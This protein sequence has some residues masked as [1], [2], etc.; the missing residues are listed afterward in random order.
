[1]VYDPM[2][3]HVPTSV[4]QSPLMYQ[5]QYPPHNLLSQPRILPGM[6]TSNQPG[7]G[8]Y[9]TANH[10]I[11]TSHMPGDSHIAGTS[12]MPGTNLIQG[13]AQNRVGQSMQYP[14]SVAGE[15]REGRE[16]RGSFPGFN[17]DF[18]QSHTLAYLPTSYAR[19]ST[20]SPASADPMSL[21]RY[22][23]SSPRSHGDLGFPGNQVRPASPVVYV[24]RP[25]IAD[26]SVDT[27]IKSENTL[28]RSASHLVLKLKAI[29][30]LER[31]RARLDIDLA[32]LKG[33]IEEWDAEINQIIVDKEDFFQDKTYQNL[34]NRKRKHLREIKELEKYEEELDKIIADRI[35]EQEASRKKEELTEVRQRLNQGVIGD[36]N[37]QGINIANV[38][39]PP[40]M[41]ESMMS[42]A[43]LKNVLGNG[44]K[45]I[46]GQTKEHL[47]GRKGP[48]NSTSQKVPV[49]S[50][51]NEENDNIRN[52]Q[53]ER[54]KSMEKIRK[55]FVLDQNPFSEPSPKQDVFQMN[56]PV[57]G[58]TQEKIKPDLMA[59]EGVSYPPKIT[60]SG[61]IG[62]Q[63]DQN[64]ESKITETK[65]DVVKPKTGSIQ[66]K[67]S[68]PNLVTKG[69]EE[70][71]VKK[72]L[73]EADLQLWECEHCTF[74]N[75][76]S[77]NVCAV[78][79]KTND[80]KR[81]IA[82]SGMDLQPNKPGGTGSRADSVEQCKRCTFH[83]D[84]GADICQ[85]CGESLPKKIGLPKQDQLV[86]PAT[87][88]TNQGKKDAVS[89]RVTS[90]EQKLEEEQDQVRKWFL[91]TKLQVI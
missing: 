42:G 54:K 23:S 61:A 25:N 15:L 74:V 39:N 34:N 28:K 67:A 26:E 51:A 83:N 47:H 50:S 29:P 88:G 44:P 31:R 37:G 76:H 73:S 52:D 30:D 6:W 10:M 66:Q 40:T 45:G 85:M 20:P 82:L 14:F 24:E 18:P 9:F 57:S 46:A 64:M 35:K 8:Q 12:Q 69:K 4:P 63:A 55:M 79:C 41:S 3:Y 84:K 36:A 58:T 19:T 32:T 91:L 16:V 22:S 80:Q 59:G 43:S 33:D 60:E 2:I 5:P 11:G 7:S 86:A 81:I 77:N 38:N 62:V 89:P 21:H 1:M 13:G 49:V 27:S 56:I 53:E 72:V 87:G 70:Q 65:N 17:Q 68:E 48:E 90:L 78:C 75:E 71:P